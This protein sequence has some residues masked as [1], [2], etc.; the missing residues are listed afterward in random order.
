MKTFRVK[1]EVLWAFQDSDD[2]YR[3]CELNRLGDGKQ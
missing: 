3:Q 2:I 1:K